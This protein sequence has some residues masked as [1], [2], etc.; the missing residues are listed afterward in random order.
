MVTTLFSGI[1][2]FFLEAFFEI[3]TELVPNFVMYV[4]LWCPYSSYINVLFEV[5]YKSTW[6]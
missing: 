6:Q 5:D 3:S 1:F 4:D 2:T